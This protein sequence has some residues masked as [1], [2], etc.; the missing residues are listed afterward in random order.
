MPTTRIDRKR[1]ARLLQKAAEEPAGYVLPRHNQEDGW[2]T[3]RWPLRRGHLFLLPG[4]S[5][6]GYRL[7]LDS[8]PWEAAP[9]P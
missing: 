7:P 3:S 6:L 8:L 4:D 9:A 1:L 5:S 2:R